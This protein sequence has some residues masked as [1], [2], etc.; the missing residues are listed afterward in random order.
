MKRFME[1]NWRVAFTVIAIT[2]PELMHI[3]SMGRTVTP[4]APELGL[5]TRGLISP[6]ALYPRHQTHSRER[7]FRVGS[8]IIHS[9]IERQASD[10]RGGNAGSESANKFDV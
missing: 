4:H 1:I 9:Q 8:R 2:A 7:K 6:D 5:F 3:G 10:H